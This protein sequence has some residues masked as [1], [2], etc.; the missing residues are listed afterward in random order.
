MS[1][2]SRIDFFVF[3]FILSLT[4]AVTLIGR[5]GKHQE[6]V[7]EH[8]LMGR[9]LSLPLFVATLVATWYGGIFGVTEVVFRH[10]IYGFFTQG[11]F[12]YLA[13]LTFALLLAERVRT[14]EALSL[15]D[16]VENRYGKK[17]ARLIAVV[18]CFDMLPISYVMSCG[19]FL[20]TLFEVPYSLGMICGALFVAFYAMYGGFRAIVYSDFV[21]FLVMIFSVLL[22]L[23]FSLKRN[24]ISFLVQELPI[25]HWQV[26]SNQSFS[27]MFVWLMLAMATL[28]NPG[29][30]QRCLAA[31]NPVVAKKGVLISIVIWCFFDLCTCLGGMYARAI[32]PD[33]LPN[34]AYLEYSLMI[35]PN[36]FRGFFL[37][38][39]FST[40]LST[41]DSNLLITAD[42]L[43]RYLCPFKN[44][45][46]RVAVFLSALCSVV[47]A[48]CF[49]GSILKVW[50][51]IG[52]LNTGALLFPMVMAWWKPQVLNDNDFFF[53]VI[54]GSCGVALM[55]VCHV[56]LLWND[57]PILFGGLSLS[58]FGL[59]R[60][61]LKK[62][63][64][65]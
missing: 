56:F 18:N 14:S 19:F 25:E 63:S 6:D 46:H 62:N 34:T 52:S 60:I 4:F 49:D 55:F 58:F 48:S 59:L 40:I 12:W 32:L 45:S 1:A 54:M 41:L 47:M 3:F 30:Y 21:Q 24:P 15:P 31:K 61:F 29:F 43:K 26:S 9:Q 53:L 22:V 23:V 20:K 33:S 65:D 11:V 28:V 13:Y 39:I 51:I 38:G 42:T 37:A 7:L 50:K 10:G 16:F 5:K 8:F 27:E 35:L 36:G 2:L 44:L 57:I 64:E 17:S